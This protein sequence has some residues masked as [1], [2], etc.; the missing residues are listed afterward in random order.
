M[1]SQT[2]GMCLRREWT[3]VG[4][5]VLSIAG[6]LALALPLVASTESFA[7]KGAGAAAYGG[8]GGGGGGHSGGGGRGGG[9][10]G[11]YGGGY[12]G[13]GHY[14]GRRFY[15]GG[16]L[17]FGGYYGGYYPYAVGG[18]YDDDCYVVRRRVLTPYGWRVRRAVV[19]G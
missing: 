1:V 17:G 9:G 16:G 12:G 7:Q 10:G 13:G 11:H 3:M 5:K 15:G 19:C 4:L 14:G 18:Y 2:V 6:V 8:G